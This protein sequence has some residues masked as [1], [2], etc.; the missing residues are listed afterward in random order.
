[1]IARDLLFVG[2][3][4][5]LVVFPSSRLALDPAGRAGTGGR[6]LHELEFDDDSEEENLAAAAADDPTADAEDQAR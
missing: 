1:V 5:W 4:A 6:A 2:M 3:S